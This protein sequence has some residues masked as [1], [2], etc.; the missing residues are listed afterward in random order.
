MINKELSELKKELPDYN[1]DDYKSGIYQ[2]YNRR[3]SIKNKCFSKVSFVSIIVIMF[4]VIVGLGTYA[5]KVEAKEYQDASDF[6]EVNE[7][8]TDGLSRYE[9]KE[10]YKDI[11]TNKFEYKKTGEVI[12]QSIK[13]KVPGYSIELDNMTSSE[14]ISVWKLWDKLRE[15]KQNQ[16]T[17]VYYNYDYGRLKNDNETYDFTKYIFKKYENGK[18]C[19]S[20]DIYYAIT[21]YIEKDDYLII[22]GS[23]LY[24]YSTEVTKKTYITKVSS[25]GLII[26]QQEFNDAKRFYRI[27]INDDDSLIVFTNKTSNNSY[28]IIYHLDSN[29]VI[30]D[31]FE[32]YFQDYQV[33]DVVKLE[34]FYLVYLQDENMNCKFAKVCFDGRLE[35]EI[36]Y[37]DANY[38]YFFTDMIEYE[39]QVYLSAYTVPYYEDMNSGSRAEIRYILDSV[40]KLEENDSIVTDEYVLNLFKNQYKAVLL[41]C[42]KSNGNLNTFYSVD[43]GVGSNLI[44][45][46]DNLI[47]NVEYFESMMFSPLTSSYTFGGVTQIYNYIFDELGQFIGVNKTDELRI[48]RR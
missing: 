12:T 43:G 22:Y 7:L 26:W 11:T 30:I 39:G 41:I 8:L 20:L 16:I 40:F 47:W 48:F 2:K 45:Q 18:E 10:I 27:I 33:K 9:I 13:N 3:N 42:D 32:N 37:H 31:S 29:G 21:G 35:D 46:N 36:C 17:G 34:E 24:Y 1:I 14:L 6:F 23:E 25:N 28:L 44:I 4:I 5:I 15:E 38:V 19:W